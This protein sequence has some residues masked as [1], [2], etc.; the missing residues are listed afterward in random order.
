MKKY[1]VYLLIKDKKPVYIGCS[2]NLKNRLKSHRLSKDFDSYIVLKQ[3]RD[4]KEALSA[5]NALIRFI[6]IF[7]GD[8]WLN[9]KDIQLVFEG[10]FKGLNNSVTYID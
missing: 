6:S 10:S 1:Y 2:V 3:Y 9:S 8:E 7:G 4:K 5:E